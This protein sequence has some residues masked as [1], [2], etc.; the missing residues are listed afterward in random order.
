MNVIGLDFACDSD[1][2]EFLSLT[3]DDKEVVGQ[4]IYRRLITPRGALFEA[5]DY[6]VDLRSMMNAGFTQAT[7]GLIQQ[8]VKDEV[9]KD[10]RVNFADVRV[11]GNGQTMTMN[12]AIT[13]D[14]I[15]GVVPLYLTVSDVT[16]ELLRGE[17]GAD[18]MYELPSTEVPPVV[19]T[20]PAGPVG[21]SGVNGTDGS[22]ANVTFANVKLALADANDVISFN[23]QRLV[24][25]ADAT[26]AQNAITLAGLTRRVPT[27]ANT[28][29]HYT[30]D[31]S[32]APFANS[33]TAGAL[34]LTNATATAVGKC[35]GVF[36]EG[37]SIV[38]DSSCL[39]TGAAGTS[40][41]EF[42]GNTLTVSLWVKPFK[43]AESYGKF[44]AKAYRPA[45]SGWTSP[46]LAYSIGQYSLSYFGM[47]TSWQC[48]VTVNNGSLND[49]NVTA[50][51]DMLRF[52]EWNFVALVYDGAL[53]KLKAYRNGVLVADSLVSGN[54]DFGSH[55][56]LVLGFN[57]QTGAESANVELDDVRVENVARS[58]SYLFNM[59]TRGRG[60]FDSY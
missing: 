18:A 27:D 35:A 56:P 16:V 6:G 60:W 54:I 48:S 36:G 51:R 15:Y 26:A 38:A 42:T 14:T 58:A 1:V 29:L 46:F 33:G 41:G 43:V 39:W 23:D 20:G 32:A 50:E 40:V 24:D 34:S 11:T 5:P 8:V 2:D 17:A 19:L 28:L 53:G 25:V 4:A 31:E 30:F 52:N 22:D 21:P 7:A 45:A 13:L 9:E 47:G 59:Y 49:V 44:V 37:V 55:G 57:G 3:Y 10:E 12:V